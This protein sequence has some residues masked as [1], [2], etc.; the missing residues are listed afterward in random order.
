MLLS[1]IHAVVDGEVVA[2]VVG[3]LRS[4]LPRQVLGCV[5]RVAVV[6]AVVDANP[7]GVALPRPAAFKDWICP[8]AAVAEIWTIGSV[9]AAG[10]GESTY[11][12]DTGCRTFCR[13]ERALGTPVPEIKGN[14]NERESVKRRMLQCN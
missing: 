3:R 7:A 14:G 6:F 2:D 4:L 11:C 8:A 5:S 12:G 1:G 9:E 10:P 13:K